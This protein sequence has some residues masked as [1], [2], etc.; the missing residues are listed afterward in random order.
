MPDRHVYTVGWIC[1]IQVEHTAASIFLEKS[2][3]RPDLPGGDKNSYVFGEIGGHNVVIATLPSG[4]PGSNNAAAVANDMIRTFPNIKFGLMVGVGGGAPSKTHDVRLGDVVVGVPGDGSG[5]VLQYDFGKTIQNQEFLMTGH[6][7]ESPRS[8]LGAVTTLQTQYD[9][10]RPG[11]CIKAEIEDILQSESKGI[12]M[13]YQRPH[14][15]TDRLFE[16]SYVHYSTDKNCELVC[17]DPLRLVKREKRIMEGRTT[18]HRGRVA[19]A[20]QVMR[21]AEMRDKLSVQEKVLCF[22][23]EAAGLMN[24]FPCL[25]IRGIC[26][27]SDTHKNDV[28]QGYSAM[29]SAAYAKHLLRTIAPTSVD[30]ESK[31]LEIFQDGKNL[32]AT[33]STNR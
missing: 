33:E 15:S 6:L 25:V 26:D 32:R 21:N 16:S 17:T 27:Y 30:R 14:A 1:A 24:N 29:A 22:E 4:G 20:N 18:V 11:Y 19:S 12:Q 2:H 28:W 10:D 13:R 3:D 23:M 5:G 7:N 9:R 8:L 31:V